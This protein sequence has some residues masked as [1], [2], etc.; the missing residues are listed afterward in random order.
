MDLSRQLP[1]GLILILPCFC[2]KL[3]TWELKFKG[4]RIM[5][6]LCALCFVFGL[7]AYH[8]SAAYLSISLVALAQHLRSLFFTRQ[9][10][11]PD[12]KRAM[13]CL[14]LSSLSISLCIS[15]CVAIAVFGP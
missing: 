10:N 11:M 9:T 13:R 1:Q 6:V 14:A 3:N 7:I 12:F 2:A 15:V 4:G 8:A 5:E